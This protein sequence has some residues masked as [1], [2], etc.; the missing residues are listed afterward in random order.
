MI[1]KIKISEPELITDEE[2]FKKC[3]LKY[4]EQELKEE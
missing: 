1:K 4:I 2:V 3:W